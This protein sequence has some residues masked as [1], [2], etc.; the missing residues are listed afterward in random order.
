MPVIIMGTVSMG[1]CL[2]IAKYCTNR[3]LSKNQALMQS[4][5]LKAETFKDNKINTSISEI[6]E[7]RFKEEIRVLKKVIEYAESCSKYYNYKGQ[8][9]EI[10]IDERCKRFIDIV[11]PLL[12]VSPNEYQL[13]IQVRPSIVLYI[14]KKIKEYVENRPD[15]N[16]VKSEFSEIYNKIN[17]AQDNNKRDFNIDYVMCAICMVDKYG[18]SQEVLSVAK[19]IN[20][21]LYS[22]IFRIYD[23]R[24][25]EVEN[26]YDFSY[27]CYKDPENA[28]KLR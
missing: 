20:P 16:K 15:L 4:Y 21:D 27:E 3:Q 19:S 22:S 5:R 18:F 1:I 6:D 11:T 17:F 2:Y 8:E 24:L 25:R 10:F 13:V 14:N 26:Y 23:Q 7:S 28:W 9:A 12:A